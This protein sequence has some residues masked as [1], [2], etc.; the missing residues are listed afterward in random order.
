MNFKTK[1]QK[2]E[3]IHDIWE[4]RNLTLF[5]RCLITK[6]LVISQLIHSFLIIDIRIDYIKAAYSAKKDKIK[7]KVMCLDYD[8]GGLRTPSIECLNH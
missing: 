2:I 3:A 7:R 8:Q 4:Y 1:I 5:G 6:T